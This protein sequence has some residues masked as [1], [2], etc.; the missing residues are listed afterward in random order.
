MATWKEPKSDYVKED[1]VV[2]EIFNNLAENEKYLQEK[3]I[4]TEQVQDAEIT[5]TQSASRESVGDKET[6]KGFFGKIRKWLADLK[7]LAFKGT[8]ATADIDNSA[9]TSAKLATNAVTTAK[10]NAKAVTDAKIDTVSASKVT[11]LHKVATSG[12]YNDLTD[13]P[14]GGGGISLEKFEYSLRTNYPLKE[15]LFLCYVRWHNRGSIWGVSGCGL[16]SISKWAEAG[17]YSGVSAVYEGDSIKIQI[18]CRVSGDTMSFYMYES[19][20]GDG[21]YAPNDS[22]A[23]DGGAEVVL[24]KLG[25]TPC[26]GQTSETESGLK[27]WQYL[28]VDAAYVYGDSSKK[29]VEVPVAGLKVGDKIKATAMSLKANM[30]YMS[31]SY[32]YNTSNIVYGWNYSGGR[33][34][35]IEN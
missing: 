18:E 23:F 34:V 27:S 22:G 8:V 17:S 28:D 12:S 16:L 14:S 3:K 33:W 1:Q 9:V 30:D 19:Q 21:N 31:E 5:S 29:S 35:Q 26:V 13:K 7:A 11:G 2:P 4:T 6:V 10:I 25:D 15:G 24:Y 32:F 20:D